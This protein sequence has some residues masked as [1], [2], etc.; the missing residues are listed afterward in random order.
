MNVKLKTGQEFKSYGDMMDYF[1]WKRKGG[2]AKKSQMK[3]IEEYLDLE[4]FGRYGLKIKKIKKEVPKK[5]PE[6]P[7]GG[8]KSDYLA[9]MKPIIL[10]AIANGYVGDHCI[11]CTRK[12]FFER[13]ELVNKD[14][15]EGRFHVQEASNRLGIPK[16]ALTYF[17]DVTYSNNVS[18]IETV[19]N[20]L[21]NQCYIDWRIDWIIK[22]ENESREKE[23]IGEDRKII[24]QA[25]R[26][27]FEEL[28]L[29]KDATLRD[30]HLNGLRDEYFK[31]IGDKCRNQG[32]QYGYIGYIITT[33]SQFEEMALEVKEE[34]DL[35]Q[36]INKI[37]YEKTLATGKRK[38]EQ[39]KKEYDELKNKKI[40]G[41]PKQSEKEREIELEQMVREDSYISWSQSY[42]DEFI[43]KIS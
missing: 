33:S 39:I 15:K 19:L 30:V 5:E 1:G 18:S 10:S 36:K 32:I 20:N 42:A 13:M 9:Y 24:V 38:Q 16:E 17:F 4:K 25:Q 23:A 8:R 27:S 14:Y 40:M 12:D 37:S 26:D 43:K 2:D 29:G 35:L 7:K 6:K 34:K 28:G 41:R 3:I 11:L 21:K 22:K 31:K